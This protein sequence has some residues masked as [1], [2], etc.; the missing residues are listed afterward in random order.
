M[1]ALLECALEDG[2]KNKPQSHWSINYQYVHLA[3]LSATTTPTDVWVPSSH[4]VPPQRGRQVNAGLF[5][6]FGLNR[7]WECSVE[8]HH[9][10]QTT[11]SNT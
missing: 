7:E 5:A 2:A 1:G 8:L 9:K 4:L 10:D 11:W 3:S 6:I